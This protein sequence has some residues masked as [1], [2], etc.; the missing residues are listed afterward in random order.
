MLQ[1]LVS[2]HGELIHDGKSYNDD[3]SKPVDLKKK[4]ADQRQILQAY[5]DRGGDGGCKMTL[6]YR[7][8]WGGEVRGRCGAVRGGVAGDVPLGR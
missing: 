8:R 3:N 2:D 7:S 6:Y 5:L 4:V 1:R